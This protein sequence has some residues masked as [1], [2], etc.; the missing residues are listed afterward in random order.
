MALPD[1]NDRREAACAW[2]TANG[3]NPNDVPIDADLSIDTGPTGRFIRCE[4]FDR[5]PDGS[6]RA[7]LH[8]EG[9]AR[10]VINVPLKTAPPDWWQPH[11]KPTRDQLLKAADKVRALH[12]RNEHSGVCEHCSERDYPD[13]EVPWPCPTMHALG[14]IGQ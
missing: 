12:K 4:V 1:N 2:L 5:A 11:V 9:P 8:G 10:L 7:D 13:Y 3:I 6:F 14:S